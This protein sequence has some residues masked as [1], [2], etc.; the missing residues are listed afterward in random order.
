MSLYDSVCSRQNLS[1]T[2]IS[3]MCGAAAGGPFG[4]LIG[5][6]A[7]T[8]SK[9]SNH[10]V[11]RFFGCENTDGRLQSVTQAFLKYTVTAGITYVISPAGGAGVHFCSYLGSFL[12]VDMATLA[13]NTIF[14]RLD[15]SQESKIR[16]IVNVALASV[17]GEIGSRAGAKVGLKIDIKN[18]PKAFWYGPDAK[19]KI[20]G[21][22]DGESI[23][24]FVNVKTKT[25]DHSYL[26]GFE[27]AEHFFEQDGVT[28][29]FKGQTGFCGE[30]PSDYQPVSST[31]LWLHYEIMTGRGEIVGKIK[32]YSHS[33]CFDFLDCGIPELDDIVHG[34]IIAETE[35][36]L[37][38]MKVRDSV[39]KKHLSRGG[40][41]L[42]DDCLRKPGETKCTLLGTKPDTKMQ[43]DKGKDRVTV[44]L[45]VFF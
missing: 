26:C 13:S 43:T 7:P 40:E 11:R 18:H 33:G 28:L 35:K 12:A 8:I 2:F 9:V 1:D 42:F 23:S 6:F 20:T 10:T 44:P 30:L 27:C 19:L 16:F 14:D 21:S 17:C 31:K 41:P 29:S 3:S 15:V 25:G 4:A 38:L 34:F 39:V 5:G 36:D 22:R 24:G 32:V 37:E 45:T